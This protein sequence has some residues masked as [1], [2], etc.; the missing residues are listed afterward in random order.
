MPGNRYSTERAAANLE[1]L[2]HE[3][4]ECSKRDATPIPAKPS[5][6]WLFKVHSDDRFPQKQPAAGGQTAAQFRER[7]NRVRQIGEHT[8]TGNQVKGPVGFGYATRPSSAPLISAPSSASA[9]C[10]GSPDASMT[11]SP[12]CSPVKDG[13]NLMLVA[14]PNA[15]TRLNQASVGR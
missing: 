4:I 1:S 5:T 2:P 10:G 9:G 14:S 11:S 3:I 8:E 12:A 15:S 7:C 13:Q 6:F